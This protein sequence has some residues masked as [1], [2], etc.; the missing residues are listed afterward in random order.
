MRNAFALTASL[1]LVGTASP[2]AHAQWSNYGYNGADGDIVRCESRDGRT[3]RCNT[4]GG[5]AQ[6]VR[7]LSDSACIRNRTWG[8]D[9]Q[10]LWV[11]GGCRAEF[12]VLS[13]YDDG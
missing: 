1:L 4:Y 13:G 6:L 11:S 5:D 10:G 8:V 12:R 3:S 9:Y 2:P 7:Q